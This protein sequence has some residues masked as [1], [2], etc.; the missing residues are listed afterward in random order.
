MAVYEYVCRDCSS[1]YDVLHLGKENT[2]KIV[3]PSCQSTNYKK[4]LSVFNAQ[5]RPSTGSRSAPAP[6]CSTGA[7]GIGGG[8][9][10]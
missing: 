4:L 2:D 8:C 5:T 6:S 7:C 10:N 1:L 9:F 3:C